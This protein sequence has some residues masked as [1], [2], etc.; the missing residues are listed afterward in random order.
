MSSITE[1]AFPDPLLDEIR[2]V[3]ESVSAR[4][5]HDVRQLC[6][7]LRREQEKSPLRVVRRKRA[8]VSGDIGGPPRP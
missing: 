5:G 3:K 6:E 2:A 8:P 7:H 1:S 4:F